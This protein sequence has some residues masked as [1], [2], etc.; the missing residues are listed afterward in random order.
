[1]LDKDKFAGVVMK[2]HIYSN[3]KDI[4]ALE[5]FFECIS[6]CS[7]DS[8]GLDCTNACYTKY[9]EPANINYPLKFL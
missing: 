2:K 6:S 7:I 9:L 1:M 4:E 8:E 5:S 3:I